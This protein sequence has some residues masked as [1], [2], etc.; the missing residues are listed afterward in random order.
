MNYFE[1]EK[2]YKNN[3]KKAYKKADSLINRAIKERDTKGYRENLGYDSLNKLL[4]YVAPF[5]LTYHDECA[6]KDYHFTECDLI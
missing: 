5:H 1:K 4:D 3:L 2:I 6:L